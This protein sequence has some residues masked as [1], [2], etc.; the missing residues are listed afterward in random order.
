MVLGRRNPTA[1]FPD[2]QIFRMRIFAPNEVVAKSRFWYFAKLHISQL[3]KN[4]GEI[5]ACSVIHE[6]K[7]LKV[8]NFGIWLRYDS[9][10]GTHNMYKE[11]RDLTRTGAVEQMYQE[12]SGRH[13]CRWSSLRIIR[14]DEITASQARRKSTLQMLNNTLK[15]PLPAHGV[16]VP[17]S[18]DHRPTYIHGTP[19]LSFA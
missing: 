14:V 3:K 18:K 7:P 19:S 17:K 16:H 9:R 5:L 1:V 11:Y 8:K 6:K 4:T 13:R 2:P 10:S 12:M 15:F